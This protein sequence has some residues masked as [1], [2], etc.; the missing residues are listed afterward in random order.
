MKSHY[1]ELGLQRVRIVQILSLEGRKFGQT[2]NTGLYLL[3]SL[4]E[5]LKQRGHTAVPGDEA[6][7]LYDT[8]GF[9]LELTQEGAAEQGFTV[10][11]SGFEQSIQRQQARSRAPTTFAH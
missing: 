5:E 4:L 2:L 1:V 10:D 3:N 9:P 6:F 8:H 11:F 7:K